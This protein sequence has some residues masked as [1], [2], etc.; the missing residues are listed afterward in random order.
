MILAWLFDLCDG[1][2]MVRLFPVGVDVW[3][4]CACVIAVPAEAPPRL[5][6]HGGCTMHEH[7]R[8]PPTLLAAASRN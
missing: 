6:M 3:Y 4:R 7:L 8:R 1:V 2:V 5:V